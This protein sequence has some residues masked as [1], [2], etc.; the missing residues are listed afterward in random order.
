MTLKLMRNYVN[1]K[2]YIINIFYIDN[3]SA[4]ASLKNTKKKTI[5]RITKIVKFAVSVSFF[6]NGVAPY[7]RIK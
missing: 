6:N 5:Q 1:H 2:K 3:N 7:Y 4:E